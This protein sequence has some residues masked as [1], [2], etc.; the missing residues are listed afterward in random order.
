M[1]NTVEI[2]T[3]VALW[4]ILLTLEELQFEKFCLS[5]IW[6]LETVWYQIDSRWKVFSLGKSKCLRQPI[7]TQLCQKSKTFSQFCAK[8]TKSTSNF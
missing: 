2:Y 3:A 1:P 5:S 6:N 7:Q 4:Y 8:L